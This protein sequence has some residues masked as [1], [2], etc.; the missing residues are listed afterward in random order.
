[1]VSDMT[2]MRTLRG[3]Q[4]ETVSALESA[5][6][7]GMLRP[8]TVQPTGSG[9]TVEFAH[10]CARAVERGQRPMVLVHRNELAEQTLSKLHPIPPSLRSGLIKAN[11][12]QAEAD[13]IVGSIQTLAR[14]NRRQEVPPGP[15]GVG[16]V[17]EG[18]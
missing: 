7:D 15:V 17:D 12:R 4:A 1:M 18:T 16:V 11:R 3:Y 6:S 5:W 8:A 14:G 10:M 9:K 13:V 2:R